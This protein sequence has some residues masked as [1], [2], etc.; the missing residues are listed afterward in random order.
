MNYARASREELIAEAQAKSLQFEPDIKRDRLIAMLRATTKPGEEEL[1]GL[2]HADLVAKGNEIGV[3]WPISTQN[4]TVDGL[5]DL[6][7][8]HTDELLERA[9]EDPAILRNDPGLMGK[10][11]QLMDLMLA[12][13]ELKL[14]ELPDGWVNPDSL[15]RGEMVKIIIQSSNDSG[16]HLAQ[17]VGINGRAWLIPRDIAVEVPV[18]VLHALMDAKQETYHQAGKQ[19]PLTGAIPYIKR[20]S[21]RFGLVVGDIAMAM[22]A[23]KPKQSEELIHS[24]PLR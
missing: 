15:S 1:D 5:I 21:Q 6:I 4:L 17:P 23:N 22:Q 20:I 24:Y 10:I 7:E 12:E 2:S 14:G 13:R 18:A 19:D 16:G 9:A 11:D 8:D 3:R